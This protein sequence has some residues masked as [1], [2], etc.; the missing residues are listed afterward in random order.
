[1]CKNKIYHQSGQG[2]VAI[3]RE[4]KHVEMAYGTLISRISKEEFYQFVDYVNKMTHWYEDNQQNQR[5]EVHLSMLKGRFYM[6]LTA[7]ELHQLAYVV[8]DAQA[9]MEVEELLKIA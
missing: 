9:A 6:V 3:C 7:F 8:N 2:Y 1:M 4:C 5:K